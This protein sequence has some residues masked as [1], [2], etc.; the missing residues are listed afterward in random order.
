MAVALWRTR[1]RQIT[2][3]VLRIDGQ[4]IGDSTAIIAALEERFPE[5]PLYPAD[6]DE[7]RR[8][9]ELEDWFD[10]E[11]GPYIRRLG[12][13]ELRR[14]RERFD[15]VAERTGPPIAARLGRAG[16]IYGR[17][18]VGLRFGARKSDA[19]ERAREKVIAALDRL[20]E[21]LGDR[22][23]LVGDRFTVADLTAAA[24]F[25]PLVLPPQVSASGKIGQLPEPYERF[26]SSLRERRGYRWVEEIF[27]RHRRGSGQRQEASLSGSR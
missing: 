4:V 11:L 15:A 5:P 20:E 13:Y 3:P 14:D 2:L 10:E 1:G 9:L 17:A 8:A 16:G 25:Y 21:E 12:F 27:R 22:D 24:L 18:L 7:R 6:P 19:A 23:Y 26:R